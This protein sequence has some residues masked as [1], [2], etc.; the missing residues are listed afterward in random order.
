MNHSEGT[1]RGTPIGSAK[2]DTKL[3]ESRSRDS[4]GMMSSLHVLH[5]FKM[6]KQHFH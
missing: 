2:V 3:L 6:L 5:I 4:D 1:R